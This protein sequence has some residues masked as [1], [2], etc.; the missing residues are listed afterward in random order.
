MSSS[1]NLSVSSVFKIE[2]EGRRESYEKERQTDR[3][4]Q[5]EK[6]RKRQRE[7]DRQTELLERV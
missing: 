3:E 1:T 4:R 2:R 5:R 6:E 7:T